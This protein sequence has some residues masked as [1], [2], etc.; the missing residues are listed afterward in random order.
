MLKEKLKH[1][2]DFFSLE[3]LINQDF[4][5]EQ[6]SKYYTLNKYTYSLFHS[7]KFTHMWI[8]KNEFEFTKNDLL[9]QAI[10]IEKILKEN[11]I[12]H[13]LELA[14]WRWWTI[15]Y[16]AKQYNAIQ[17]TWMD[18]NKDQL[19]YCEVLDNAKFIQWDYHHLP[20]DNN[21]FELVFVIEALCHSANKQ[22]VFSEINRV[23]SNWWYCIVIDWYQAKE[24]LNSIENVSLQLITKWMAVQNFETYDQVKQDAIWAWLT[25]VDEKN[26]SKNILPTTNRFE[27]M[28]TLFFRFWLIAKII[29]KLIPNF[30]SMNIISWYLM[31]DAIK[32]QVAT[33]F[34]TCF[35]KI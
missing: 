32:E 27:K 31:S 28:S 10:L 34:Y 22:L 35:N 23:L 12:S 33:Y 20:F 16:L 5:I 17:F 24:S 13:V 1:L 25:L 9:S 14:C 15:N 6:T 19:S 29:I 11:K 8:S 4:T 21:S 30:I 3:K 7:K 26:Y 18:Y 2:C